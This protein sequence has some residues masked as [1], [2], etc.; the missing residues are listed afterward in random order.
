MVPLGKYLGPLPFYT[1]RRSE[2][3]LSLSRDDAFFAVISRAL[4]IADDLYM[5]C[6]HD[7]RSS[8]KYSP[9]AICV[10]GSSLA[11]E[12]MHGDVL[13]VTLLVVAVSPIA[14]EQALDGNA[15]ED[16]TKERA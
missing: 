2:G 8:R 15:L 12:W 1:E 9:L 10:F 14:I 13:G 4:G 16:Q 5:R 7:R 3:Y 6:P 11:R